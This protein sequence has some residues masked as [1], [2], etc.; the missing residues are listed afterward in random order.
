MMG[1]EVSVEEGYIKA[2]V[3]DGRLTGTKMSLTP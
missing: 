1:A 3:N 2:R